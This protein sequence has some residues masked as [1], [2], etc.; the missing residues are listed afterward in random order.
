MVVL[1]VVAYNRVQESRAR[2][3]AERAFGEPKPDALMGEAAPP[4][5]GRPAQRAAALA[6]EAPRLD[7]RLDYLIELRGA[8]L[9]AAA[10]QERWG[11]IARRHGARANLEQAASGW[12]AGL[13]LVSRDGTVGEAE[14]IEF[15]AGIEDLAAALGAS[16]SAPEMKGALEAARGLD[17]LCAETDLQVVLH[18]VAPP[19][20]RFAG[21]KLRAAAESSGLTLEPPGRFALRNDA[22]ELLYTLAA[23]DG[24][25]FAAE[26]L[27]TAAPAAV[28]LAMDVPR[29]PDTQRTFE[30]MA[31]LSQ[32]LAT[33]LGGSVVDDNDRPLDERALGA[34]AAQLEAVRAR[35]EAEGFSPGSAPALRLFA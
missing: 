34:I 33:V 18:V 9:S 15:R 2:R 5:P 24:T 10:L 31:R 32:H 4:E 11:A 19:E 28:S 3:A 27:R 35:L 13:Q 6:T 20:G 30:S 26:T 1:G 23:R 8:E 21:T 7:A 25:P 16:A 12:R 29:A 22:G 14:L 17:A